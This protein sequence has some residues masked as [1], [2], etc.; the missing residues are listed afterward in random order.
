MHGAGRV[1]G[2]KKSWVILKSSG[3]RIFIPFSQSLLNSFYLRFTAFKYPWK[4]IFL[5][6]SWLPHNQP[7][8][9]L[10]K[11]IFISVVNSNLRQRLPG[12]L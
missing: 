12:V 9:S 5:S 4:Y 2:L 3:M 6:A 10:I 11:L 1:N 7:E 8:L